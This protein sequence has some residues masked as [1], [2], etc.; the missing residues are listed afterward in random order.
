MSKITIFNNHELMFGDFT[1]DDNAIALVDCDDFY[2]D[3]FLYIKSESDLKDIEKK[4]KK[5][6]YFVDISW[7]KK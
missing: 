3:K 1:A 2:V 6:K 5:W 4:S 7:I